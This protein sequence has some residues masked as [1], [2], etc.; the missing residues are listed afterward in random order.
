MKKGNIMDG[1]MIQSISGFIFFSL[2]IVLFPYSAQ[3]QQPEPSV[4]CD[5]NGEPVPDPFFPM[6][7]GDHTTGCRINPAVDVDQFEFSGS[8]G[9]KIRIIVHGKTAFFDPRLEVRDPMGDVIDDTACAGTSL[10]CSFSVDISLIKS[11]TYSLT[12]SEAGR[13]GNEGCSRQL[14]RI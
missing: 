5:E 12:R 2:A 10:G 1:R 3:A 4:E 14:A 6:N 8:D 13:K 7:Y 11:G 9:D